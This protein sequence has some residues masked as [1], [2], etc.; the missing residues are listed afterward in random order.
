M[1]SLGVYEAL[2]NRTVQ[3]NDIAQTFQ[4]VDTGNAEIGLVALSQDKVGRDGLC[5]RISIGRSVRTPRFYVTEQTMSVQK[6]FLL[7]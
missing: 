3:G 2:S 5:R 4:F 1:K 7:S 6:P